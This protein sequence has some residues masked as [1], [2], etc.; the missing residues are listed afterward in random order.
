MLS[1]N[2][3]SIFTSTNESMTDDIT[4]R[5]D[6]VKTNLIF[7][8]RCDRFEQ[9]SHTETLHKWH[10]YVRRNYVPLRKQLPLVYTALPV[11]TYGLTLC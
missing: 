11:L 6:F 2:L 7:E 9:S 4:C 1:T 10:Y 8:P 5:D 3:S